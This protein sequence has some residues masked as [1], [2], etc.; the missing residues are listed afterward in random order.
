MHEPEACGALPAQQASSHIDP[1]AEATRGTLADRHASRSIS[2]NTVLAVRTTV[3]RVELRR[4]IVRIHCANSD[5]RS[6]NS[7]GFA[8]NQA[9]LSA[10]CLLPSDSCGLPVLP[11]LPTA[12]CL[13][14]CAFCLVPSAL[15]LLPTASCL[16]LTAERAPAGI[17]TPNQQ[18]M[19]RFERH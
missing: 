8:F 17:R 10:V 2:A 15:C 5:S 19:R 6:E 11:F 4:F 1:D 14:P 9:Q 3:D 7:Q 18:I 16:L 13:L 12:F